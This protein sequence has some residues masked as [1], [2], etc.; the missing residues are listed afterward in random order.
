MRCNF[1]EMINDKLAYLVLHCIPGFSKWELE[2]DLNDFKKSLV[3]AAPH[4]S[5]WDAF[6]G[7]HLLAKYGIKHLFLGKKELFKRPF[8]GIVRWFG[9]YPVGGIKGHNS[10]TDVVKVFKE[11]EDIHIVICPEGQ[12]AP[13]DK[14]NPG[15]V[16]IAQKANVPIHVI[17][18]DYKKRKITVVGSITDTSDV[19]A[20]MRQL[21]DYYRG[22]TGKHPEC[23]QLPVVRQ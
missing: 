19:R 16:Y 8:D 15:F 14:W 9:C 4:T 20:V 12:L 11:Y 6:V 1:K 23:F 17:A 2:G 21:P 13:T 18:I 7:K 22:V 5:Y 3:I 10:I